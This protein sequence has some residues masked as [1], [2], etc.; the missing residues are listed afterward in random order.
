[1]NIF[2]SKRLSMGQLPLTDNLATFLNVTG[3]NR[4]KHFFASRGWYDN[5]GSK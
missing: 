2:V 4:D 5:L 3:R 1:M